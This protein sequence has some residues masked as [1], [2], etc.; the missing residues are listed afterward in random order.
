[1]NDF[2]KLNEKIFSFMNKIEL[3]SILSDIILKNEKMDSKFLV[4]LQN[5]K[6]N[7]LNCENNE[8]ESYKKMVKKIQ[9]G[10]LQ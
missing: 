8:L 7:I 10:E 2:E 6:K 5:I 9:K 3:T 4:S 1:M